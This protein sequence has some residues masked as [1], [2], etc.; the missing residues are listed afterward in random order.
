MIAIDRAGNAKTLKKMLKA[1]A[2]GKEEGRQIIIFP[3]GT[4]M[5]PGAPPDYKPAGVSAF[6]KALDLPIALVATNAG[7]CWPAKGATRT[8]G[9]IIY[10]IL[11]PLPAGLDRKSLMA[12]LET[13][14]E[15][16]SNRLI[17]EGRAEQASRMTGVTS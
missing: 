9:R 11:P 16:A 3:E 5:P 17:E 1:A 14:L 7:L 10:E 2:Q 8:P 12:N 15:T 13:A 4:R 6:N